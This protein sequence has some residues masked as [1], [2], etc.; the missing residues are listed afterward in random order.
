MNC[1]PEP[2]ALVDR[3]RPRTIAQEFQRLLED[4]VPLRS[5]GEAREDPE[6]LLAGGYLPRFRLELFDTVIYL[7]E[8][9]QNPAIRYFVAYLLQGKGA[10]RAL[11]PRIFYKDVSLVWRVASHM[12]ASDREFWIGKGD[13][14]II[15]QGDHE[16]VHSLESTTDLP[17]EMQDALERLNRSAGRVQE[18][19]N[20]LYLVLRNA[21]DERVEPYA[22]FCAPR[23]R[24]RNRGERIHGGRRVARFT[25]A[26]DPTSLSFARGFEPDLVD[27]VF[28]I[29]HLNSK[30][31]GGAL[32]RYRILSTNGKIQYM[33][34]AGPRHIWIVPPQA[35]TTELS[36][37]GVRVVDVEA[38]ED[39]FVP[40]YEYH[41][42]DPDLDPPAIV[43]QIPAGFA[44]ATHPFDPDRADASKWLNR[45]SIVRE[46]RRRFLQ[47]GRSRV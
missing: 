19:E 33:F 28:E 2:S 44:G 36:S 4:G 13:V 34:F 6:S 24:A 40:G 42:M 47:A 16:T 12:I 30:L 10:K 43:S 27:G 26:G 38:D 11:Y 14:R 7:T 20:A 32:A 45:L 3:R 31:Y 17:Y 1:H 25:R 23:N 46:F 39:L 29:G 41:Y 15:R 22:D 9:R 35:L 5:T 18:D 8:V 37:Y 21:P